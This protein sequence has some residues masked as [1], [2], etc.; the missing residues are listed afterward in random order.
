MLY[1]EQRSYDWSRLFFLETRV[2]W[3]S[4]K[5]IDKYWLIE[6]LITIILHVS[7]RYQVNHGCYLKVL[8]ITT[9][10]QI[11]RLESP[12]L[13]EDGHREVCLRLLLFIPCPVVPRPYQVYFTFIVYGFY[14][15]QSS[16]KFVL[17]LMKIKVTLKKRSV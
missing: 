2:M 6:L 8:L 11:F 12:G 9:W 13:V 16:L 7:T 3:V 10:E 14:M 17:F 5:K 1:A 15:I 4:F